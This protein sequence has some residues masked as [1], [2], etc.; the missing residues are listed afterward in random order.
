MAKRERPDDSPPPQTPLGLDYF[1]PHKS[2]QR[3]SRAVEIGVAV[4][5]VGWLPFACGII[6]LLVAGN[7]YSPIIAGS[8]RGGA[9]AFFAASILA[10]AF[11]LLRLATVRHGAGVLFAVV[12]LAIQLSI[13]T[14]LSAAHFGSR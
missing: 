13:V 8:H 5:I 2:R 6:N 12:V 7:S 1:A 9:V 4:V 3:P 10:S 14:C 11:G